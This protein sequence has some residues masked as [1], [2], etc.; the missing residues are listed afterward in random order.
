[1]TTLGEKIREYRKTIGWTQLQLANALDM[2]RTTIVAIEQDVR[3]VNP[4]EL[5]AMSCLFGVPVEGI[6]N[7][8]TMPDR[9]WRYV[10][11]LEIT[12]LTA[13]RERNVA[14]LLRMIADVA[15]EGD[16]E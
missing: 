15:E 16:H 9:E 11:S 14:A 5:K 7:G 13:Y 4:D 12:I 2:A 10:S 1:M 8:A 3:N 6:L